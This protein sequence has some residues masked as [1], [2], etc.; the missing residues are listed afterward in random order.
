MIVKILSRGKSFKGLA[1]YLTHDPNEKSAERVSWT[2]THNLAND[3]VPSA[4][5]EMLWTAR[6]AELLKQ[7]AGIRAGGRATENAVKHLSLNWAPDETPTRAHMIE[8]AEDFLRH[9][10]WQEHQAL[11]VAHDDKHPH[12]HVMLNVVHP[13]TGLRLNDDFERRRAQ[14]WALD[15]ERE[16]GRI[17]C[18]QRLQNV[19]EREDAP[20]RPAWMA[21]KENQRKFENEE[22]ALLEQA[23]DFSENAENPRNKNSAEWKRLKEM[24]R[25]ERQEFFADGKAAF[26]ELRL[27]IYRETR[28]EFRERWGDFYAAQKNGADSDTL[29]KMKAELIAE[30]KTTLETSRDEAC[31]ELRESRNSQ[32]REL[33]DDQREARLGLRWRQEA[34]LDNA[35]FLQQVEDRNTDRDIAAAPTFRDAANEV[36]ARQEEDAWHADDYAFT[37]SPR[38]NRSGMKSGADIS[39]N[40]G[41]GIGMG[42][43][44]FIGGIADGMVGATPEPKPRRAEPD[45]P[46]PNMFDTAFE[47]AR[48]RQQQ[49]REEADREWSRKQRSYGE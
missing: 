45:A 38:D 8:T 49:E 4:V 19:E 41:G 21:F 10:Q 1:T 34:G 46:R 43:L 47:E 30:Q 24:Q 3:H 11:L 14:A 33:L 5:D 20:T 48:Q 22:K 17:Y 36:A 2:H 37:G 44:S 9:M 27:S 6:N 13:E 23:V 40:V 42:L 25:A 32:Y 39:A 16:Q 26:S 18:E 15:Y 35:H 12:V 29:V 31:Q 7:E 28:E